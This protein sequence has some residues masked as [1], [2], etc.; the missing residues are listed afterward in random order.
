VLRF[1]QAVIAAGDL[2]AAVAELRDA[3]PLGEPYADPNAATPAPPAS[4]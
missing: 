4:R 3:L 1:R 2:D